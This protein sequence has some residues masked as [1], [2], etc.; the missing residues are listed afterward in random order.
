MQKKTKI[1]WVNCLYEKKNKKKKTAILPSEKD[2]NSWKQSG[3]K[4]PPSLV[5][6]L[7][8]I[9]LL[10]FFFLKNF[11]PILGLKKL[12]VKISRDNSKTSKLIMQ[13]NK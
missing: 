1:E 2:L 12:Y 4:P 11:I 9:S 8:L 3:D 5:K 6:D 10:F 13:M 7:V